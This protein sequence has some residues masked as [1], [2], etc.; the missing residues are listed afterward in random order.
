MP[1]AGRMR[2]K[3]MSSGSL[4]TPSTSPVSTITFSRTLVN[5]P[6]KAFQSPGTHSGGSARDRRAV[7]P[8]IMADVLPDRKTLSGG[9]RQ[10]GQ[11][12]LGRRHPAEDAA[13]RLD[14]LQ[15]HLV[16]LREIRGDAVRQHQA[17]V[18]AVVRL[19]HRR[20][21]AHLGGDAA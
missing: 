7:A 8:L 3:T 18:A 9:G 4:T 5:R 14:H 12:R 19:A 6:K 13:L 16:E 21:D 2:P 10:R 1:S 17:F 20:L 15:R 11:E